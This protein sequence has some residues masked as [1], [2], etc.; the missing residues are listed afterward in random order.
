MSLVVVGSMAFDTLQTPYGSR[1]KALG[2]SANYFSIC[3]SHFTD[4]KLVAVV[5]ED[6]P[7]EHVGWLN[8]RKIHTDGLVLAEGKTFH[9]SGRYSDDLNEAETLA[10][11]L[12]V[13]ADFKPDL[14]ESYRDADTVFLAN[15]DPELQLEV[16]NQVRD[17][18]LVAMDTM[19]FWIE[20]KNAEL[21]KLIEKV[22]IVFVNDTEARMLA[23][24]HNILKAGRAIRKMGAEVVVIKRGE[25]GALYI[26]G[27]HVFFAPAYPLEDVH[28]PTGAGDTFA[29]GFM[30][31]LD[32]HGSS[33]EVALSRQGM[34]VGTIMASFVVE[35]FS[36]DRMRSLQPE[37]IKKRWERMQEL[38][39][40]DSV[41]D[42]AK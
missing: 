6:F 17:P 26:N 42:F 38:I 30:G 13:F 10:T 21:K 32:K 2:G 22:D 27:E 34:V 5:G 33:L 15:I 8:D 39:A 23:G 20:G 7:K 3:A 40:F 29:G 31:W 41:A 12:N 19:N 28:D 16:L 11:D 37:D 35:D 9:W 1:E 25:Y 24:E 4:V 18:K 14:P 36:F